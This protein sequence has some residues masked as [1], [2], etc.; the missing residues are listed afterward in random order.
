[1]RL[2]TLIAVAAIIGS[3]TIVST[4]AAQT[5]IVEPVGSH[6]PYQRWADEAKVPTPPE[7]VS[8]YEEQGPCADALGCAERNAIYFPHVAILG[9][10]VA[11]GLFDHELGHAFDDQ[12]LTEVDH[13][14]FE[15]LLGESSPWEWEDDSTESPQEV[16]AESY[17]YCARRPIR[18]ITGVAS[19]GILVAH[20]KMQAVCRWMRTL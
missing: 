15:S 18:R 16:F 13:A 2:K 4:A 12:V 14:E 8:V 3:L 17:S 5:T 9:E 7:L 19:V 11:E 6:F 1:M 10:F 20:T